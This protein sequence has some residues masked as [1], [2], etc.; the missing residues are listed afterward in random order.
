MANRDERKNRYELRTCATCKGLY[1]FDAVKGDRPT[2]YLGPGPCV[3]PERKSERLAD[4]PADE[5]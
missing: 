2:L 1:Y 3:C 5:E 4:E